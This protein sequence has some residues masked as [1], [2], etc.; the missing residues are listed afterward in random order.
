MVIYKALYGEMKT[1]VR[2]V[3]MWNESIEANGK[4]VRRFELYGE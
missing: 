3:A 2:P 4:T 1:W